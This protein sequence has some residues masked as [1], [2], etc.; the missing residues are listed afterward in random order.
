MSHVQQKVTRF[1]EKQESIAHSKEKI[2]SLRSLMAGMF[3]K[4]FFKNYFLKIISL[5][6]RKYEQGGGLE[7]DGEANSSLTQEPN[8][9]LDQRT[10]GS[11]PELKADN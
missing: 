4:G 8:T 7:G 5:R 9:G 3:D 2:I 11:R 10:L 6:E 1:T